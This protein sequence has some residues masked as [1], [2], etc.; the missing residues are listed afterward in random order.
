[1]NKY[2]EVIKHS[3]SCN[4]KVHVKNV[5]EQPLKWQHCKFWVVHFNYLPSTLKQLLL[6]TSKD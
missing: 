3:V 4:C 6:E 5:A 1:M 2:K